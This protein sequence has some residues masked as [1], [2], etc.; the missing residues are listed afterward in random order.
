[1]PR[2]KKIGRTGLDSGPFVGDP[3]SAALLHAVAEA[4]S[5]GGETVGGRP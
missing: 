1:M 3:I 2:R 5:P 4:E